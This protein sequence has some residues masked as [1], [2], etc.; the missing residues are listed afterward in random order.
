MLCDPMSWLHLYA[1]LEMMVPVFLVRF[2][3][4][5]HRWLQA[6]IDLELAAVSPGSGS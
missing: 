2:K 6:V 4:G 1:V 3:E 5:Q